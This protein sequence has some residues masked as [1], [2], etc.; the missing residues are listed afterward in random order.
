M[1]RISEFDA[2]LVFLR[3]STTETVI[4]KLRE[5]RLLLGELSCS[6]CSNRMV[7]VPYAKCI[8]GHTWRCYKGTCEGKK[9]RISIRKNSM[10][11]ESKLSLVDTMSIVFYFSQGKSIIEA[12]TDFGISRKTTGSIYKLLR[13]Q[14]S[15]YISNEPARLGGP[16]A[17]CQVDE[18]LF[19]HKVK[20]HRGRA[21]REQVWVFGI[22][23]DIAKSLGNFYVQVVSNRSAAVLQPIF[24]QVVC[25][26]SEI[27]SDEWAAYPA[28]CRNLGLAHKIVNHSRHFVNPES[29][30]HTQ[31]I[32][33]LWN[34]LKSKIK[35]MCGVRK[36]DLQDYL[37][38]FMWRNRIQGSAFE[39]LVSLLKV[40]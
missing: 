32:E 20:A 19:C 38:E 21:P 34:V 8:D 37:N 3:S 4:F 9:L 29:G 22:L 25:D 33:S 30:V 15:S 12:S 31:N 2:V 11:S 10:F 16:G 24:E 17:V 28:I 27:Y 5:M 14:I 1:L 40:N 26:Y 13:L 39:A 36:E 18:S 35:K 23:Y 7:C 6:H